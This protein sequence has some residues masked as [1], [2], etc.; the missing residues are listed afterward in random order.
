M[1]TGDGP[2]DLLYIMCRRMMQRL[3]LVVVRLMCVLNES[4]E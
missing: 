4:D 2:Y 3:A 1:V